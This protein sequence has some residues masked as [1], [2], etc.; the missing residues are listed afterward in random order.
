M[1]AEV[2]DGWRIAIRHRAIRTN[3]KKHDDFRPGEME[4]IDGPA[5]EIQW[6]WWGGLS[7]AEKGR[8]KTEPERNGRDKPFPLPERVKSKHAGS[9][10]PGRNGVERQVRKV[11]N[12]RVQ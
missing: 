10:A 3:E 4:W 5:V 7:E 9:I 2:L 12:V 11:R 1:S 8:G 6:G